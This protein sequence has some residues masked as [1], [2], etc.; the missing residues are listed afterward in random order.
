MGSFNSESGTLRVARLFCFML[1]VPAAA[2]P[3]LN[4]RLGPELDHPAIHYRDGALRDPVSQLIVRLQ[5]GNARLQFDSP[6]GYLRSL[7]DVLNIPVES[8]IAV[9]SKTSLQKDLIEPRNPRSIF[10]NDSVSVAWMFG[11]FIELASHDPERG[12]IFYTLSQQPSAPP[13]FERRNDCL[14]CHFSDHSLGVPG[15]VISSM[16]TAPDGRPLLILGGSLV[17]DHRTPVEERWGGYYVTGGTGA[18]RNLGNAMF[19]GGASAFQSAITAGTLRLSSLKGKFDTRNY[20]WP[21]SDVA[22]L[23]VFDH[24]MHMHN[25]ITRVGWEIRAGHYDTEH[26]KAVDMRALL[27]DTAKEFVDY[28]FFIDEAPLSSAI[29]QASGS[30]PQ[31]SSAFAAKFAAEGPRDRQGRS[32]RDLDLRTRLFRYPCSYMIYSEVFETM[33]A[34]AKEAIYQ[35]M[36]QV[37]SGGIQEKKYAHLSHA[38]RRVITEILRD[39]K[40]GLPVYFQPIP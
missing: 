9:F 31:L 38:D 15:M 5:S 33:P 34:E 6:H 37:L 27:R 1:A 16:F 23:M 29:A 11:G 8:Q 22:A 7:I 21:Y 4:D 26:K 14:N 19:T 20:L 3:Q 32:L 18:I 17:V 25:L 2:L 40:K 39:T 13:R 28:L 24:Q 10:F 36:W 35:R 12:I 30:P